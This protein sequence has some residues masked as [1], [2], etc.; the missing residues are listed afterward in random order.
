MTART[1]RVATFAALLFA[2]GLV[3]ACDQAPQQQGA[4]PAEN[5]TPAAQQQSA[6]PDNSTAPAGTTTAPAERTTD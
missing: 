5:A 2:G 6:T 4:A 3:A 1:R